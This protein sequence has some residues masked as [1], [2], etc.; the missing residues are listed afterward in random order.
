MANRRSL[1][2]NVNYISDVTIG[3]CIVDSMNA[4]AERREVIS[5]LVSK[6]INLRADIISRISHTEP[7]N[8]KGF[9]KKFRVDFNAKVNEIIE[10]IGKLN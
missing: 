8:V 10:A 6:V 4:S 7:G 5:E 3:M 1:K 2:K 9:Y